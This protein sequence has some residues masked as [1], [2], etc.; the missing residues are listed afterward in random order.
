[1]SSSDFPSGAA[2]RIA[3]YATRQAAAGA[4]AFL[5]R[6]GVPAGSSGPH[7]EL[8]AGDTLVERYAV[9]VDADEWALAKDLLRRGPGLG[10]DD[11]GAVA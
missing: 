2:V 8:A 6:A 10:Q 5:R 3:Q 11:P 4:A 9:F 1:M 7:V